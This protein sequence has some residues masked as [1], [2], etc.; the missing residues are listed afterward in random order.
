MRR[1]TRG[2]SPW[3]GWRPFWSNM[4]EECRRGLAEHRIPLLVDPDL[5]Q[6]LGLKP[7]VL[8]DAILA[9]KNLGTRITDA[10]W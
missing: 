8:V 5:S 10:P 2:V 4:P 7:E 6:A 9:K 3:R 1:F